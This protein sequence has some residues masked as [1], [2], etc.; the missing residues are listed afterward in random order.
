MDHGLLLARLALCRFPLIS[1]AVPGAQLG[2]R[3]EPRSRQMS[4]GQT[5]TPTEGWASPKASPSPEP[6]S[7]PSTVP[8]PHWVGSRLE[9]H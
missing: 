7:D 2:L 1:R 3:D 5:G 6:V 4:E 9:M 8:L